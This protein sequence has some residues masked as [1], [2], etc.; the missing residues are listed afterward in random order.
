MLISMH[1][2]IIKGDL[3]KHPK[4]YRLLIAYNMQGVSTMLHTFLQ[5]YLNLIGMHLL[6]SS[7]RA[8]QIGQDPNPYGLMLA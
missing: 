4:H 8:K 2:I 7:L 1:T 6:R 3:F 5:L